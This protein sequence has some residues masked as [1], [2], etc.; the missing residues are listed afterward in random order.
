MNIMKCWQKTISSSAFYKVKLQCF[1]PR[2]LPPASH[3][4]VVAPIVLL[5]SPRGT[6]AVAARS[7]PTSCATTMGPLGTHTKKTTTRAYV[8]VVRGE[9]GIL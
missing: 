6:R 2:A 8:G 1:L 5:I 9:R 3:D 4:R 7:K